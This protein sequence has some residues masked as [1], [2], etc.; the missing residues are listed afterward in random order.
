MVVCRTTAPSSPRPRAGAHRSPWP[1]PAIQVDRRRHDVLDAAERAHWDSRQH[2]VALLRRSMM[3]RTN[4]VSMNVGPMLLT[5]MP[6]VANPTAIAL[7]N[8]S[9]RVLVMQ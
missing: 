1:P 6:N 7:V 4:G 3:C 2:E 9:K 5:R 8:P